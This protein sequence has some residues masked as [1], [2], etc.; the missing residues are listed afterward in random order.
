MHARP[1][2]S[3]PHDLRSWILVAIVLAVL[4]LLA[5]TRDSWDLGD[6]LVLGSGGVVSTAWESAKGDLDDFLFGSPSVRTP[7]RG[8]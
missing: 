1:S 4:A 3:M 7:E 5:A 8:H 6:G 2:L